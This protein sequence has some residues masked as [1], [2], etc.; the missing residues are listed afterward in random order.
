MGE[1]LLKSFINTRIFQRTEIIVS[2]YQP[3]RAHY[4][5]E[6]YDVHVS[7][8]I[9]ALEAC[10]LLILAIKPQDLSKIQLN[11]GEGTVMISLL[12]G[13]TTSSLKK[14]F[15]HARIVRTMPNLG[16]SVGFGMT[17]IY[18]RDKQVFTETE[19]KLIKQCFR[20]SGRILEVS[21][22]AAM[23]SV[24]AISGSG[25]A[26]FF[27]FLEKLISTSQNMGFSKEDS[28]LLARQTLL[29]AMEILRLNTDDTAQLWREKVT[30]KGGTTEE[31]IKAF[32]GS[33]FEKILST[34]LK[35]AENRSKE[36]GGG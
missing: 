11:L 2:E 29:G 23:D 33:N 27:Y 32:D 31:A 15:P 3:E 36:L 8:D 14:Q 34:A 18:F 21:E 10:H 25:P 28:E 17:G 1:A 16:L 6:N 7:A 30:S 19:T 9:K 35:A 5:Q 26:Y 12:A 4:L 13:I 24:T 22:E 20:A